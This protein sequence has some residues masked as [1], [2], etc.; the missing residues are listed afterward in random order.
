MRW[1]QVL[2]PKSW[3]SSVFLPS[4]LSLSSFSRCYRLGSSGLELSRRHIQEDFM[5]GRV[6]FFSPFFVYISTIFV[7][8]EEWLVKKGAEI[9]AMVFYDLIWFWQHRNHGKRRVSVRIDWNQL[10]RKTPMMQTKMSQQVETKIHSAHTD[11]DP[12]CSRTASIHQFAS[13]HYEYHYYY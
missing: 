11:I 8:W 9:M 13:P 1:R 12:I 2:E 3:P 6:V 4:S 5:L 7:S 10:K